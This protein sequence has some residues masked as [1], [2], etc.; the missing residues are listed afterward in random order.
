MEHFKYHYC[1]KCGWYMMASGTAHVNQCGN[2]YCEKEAPLSFA[3]FTDEEHE[4]FLMFKKNF[5][6]LFKK[7]HIDFRIILDFVKMA[8]DH[9]SLLREATIS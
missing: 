9:K 6:E 3:A 2:R 8:I 4:D 5:E 7:K 1:E